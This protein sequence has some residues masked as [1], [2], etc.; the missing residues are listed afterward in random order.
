MHLLVRHIS[1]Y[2]DF[3]QCLGAFLSAADA[4]RART[5]YIAAIESGS[6]PDH[7][8]EQAYQDACLENDVRVHSDVPVRDVA[9]GAS[10]IFL[11]SS[12]SEGFGQ[13]IRKFEVICGTEESRSVALSDID[14][15][16][17]E[18]PLSGHVEVLEIGALRLT[19]PV[20]YYLDSP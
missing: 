16:E 20:A 17:N 15:R 18:W 9:A 11:V 6:A 14:S 1:P 8:P 2:T 4:E 7:W 5:E 12:F 19:S 13:T 3:D 10:H